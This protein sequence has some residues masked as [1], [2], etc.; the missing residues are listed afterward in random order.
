MGG[1]HGT[2]GRPLVRIQVRHRRRRVVAGRPAESEHGRRRARRG[3]H[4]AL[5][6]GRRG[7]R[8]RVRRVAPRH[9]PSSPLS[10]NSSCWARS[11]TLR[12]SGTST[13]RNT[14]RTSRPAS[15]RSR[16]CGCTPS[17]TTTTWCPSS[18][19]YPNVQFTVN[20]TPI[21]LMQMED[22]VE[23]YEEGTGTDKYLRMTLADASSLSLDDKVYL[24]TH[25]F[26]AQWDNKIH[27]WP[28]YSDAQG[29]EGRRH[30]GRT[31]GGRCA[32]HRRR[33]GATSRRG[34]TSRGSTRTSRRATSRFRTGVS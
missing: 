15:T 34:S 2:S 28:R 3:Q 13:S 22:V 8:A 32:V 7:R 27:I 5:H 17:R 23:G 30:E 33:T 24:L 12:S 6:H 25:F 14:S 1:R 11:S 21:L 26:N 31:R 29:H 18:P 10:T 4:G 16:G 20:L 9:R 19:S